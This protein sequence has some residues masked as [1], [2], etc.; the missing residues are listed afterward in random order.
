MKIVVK[1]SQFWPKHQNG[2]LKSIKIR[3]RGLN[4][5]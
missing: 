3:P 4:L 5:F 2:E 1:K